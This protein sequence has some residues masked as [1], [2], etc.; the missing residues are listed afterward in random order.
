MRIDDKSMLWDVLAGVITAIITF[1]IL[2]KFKLNIALI[3]F[4]PLPVITGFIRGKTLSEDKSK[5]VILMNILF[6]VLILPILNGVF[7]LIL[8][9]AIAL[10]GTTLGIYVRL[11]S[12][13]SA[14]KSFGFLVLFSVSVLFIGFYALPAYLDKVSW[15]RVNK[16]APSFTLSTLEG[17]VIKSSD[18]KGKVMVLDFWATW[19]VPCKKQFPLIEKLY[20]ENKDN[21]NVVFFVINPQV[22]GDSIEKV[23]KFIEKSEYDLPFVYD[24]ESTTYKAFN[25]SALPCLVIID[26]EG[27]ISLIHTGYNE[28]ENFYEK[29]DGYLDMLLTK[30]EI[31]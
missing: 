15:D 5:K 28:S 6:F 2:E 23:R 25:V 10:I 13:I 19:C 8:I 11:N 30:K 31:P 4:S 16:Q 17:D 20:N 26:S 18:Y 9:L 3:V 1:F 21:N 12:Q 29:I 27:D 7:H 22:G 24:K 14:S